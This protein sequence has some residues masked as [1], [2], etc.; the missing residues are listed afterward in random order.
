MRARTCPAGHVTRTFETFRVLTLNFPHRSSERK[1]T[2]ATLLAEN[3][4]VDSL[5][6]VCETCNDNTTKVRTH[7]DDDVVDDDDDDDDEVAAARLRA[8]AVALVLRLLTHARRPCV[9]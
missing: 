1:Y 6:C 9:R 5:E 7:D 8:T 2:L 3:H 4:G